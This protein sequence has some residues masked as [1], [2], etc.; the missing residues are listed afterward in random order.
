MLKRLFWLF[1]CVPLL[2][3]AVLAIPVCYVV[4]DDPGLMVDWM[5]GI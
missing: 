3:V 5:F 2:F 4:W 1:A